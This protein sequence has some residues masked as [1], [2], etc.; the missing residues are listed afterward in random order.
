MVDPNE[1]MRER[2]GRVELRDPLVG[3]FYDLLRDFVHPSDLEEMVRRACDHSNMNILYSNGWLA[4]YAQ[5]MVRR[6]DEARNAGAQTEVVL[7]K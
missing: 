6:L 5:D 4:I 1:D 7:D 2:S 3:L